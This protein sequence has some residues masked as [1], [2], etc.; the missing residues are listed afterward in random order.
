MDIQLALKNKHDLDQS[1]VL[2]AY[3]GYLSEKVLVSLAEILRQKL[4]L[5]QFGYNLTKRAFGLFCEQA[6]NIIRYSADRMVVGDGETVQY[7]NG[8]I[9]VGYADDGVFVM[10]GNVID[11]TNRRIVEQRLQELQNMDE[12]ELRRYYKAKLRSESEAQSQGASVGLIEVV[13]R[14]TYPIEYDFIPY[15]DSTLFF[16]IKAY[17]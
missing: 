6:Q 2:V 8:L 3:N 9:T 12:G 14:S 10:C 1:N 11:K 4:E 5:D 15:G 13:R 17:A 16:C 7:G